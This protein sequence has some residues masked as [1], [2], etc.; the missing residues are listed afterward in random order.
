M[1][2]LC[3]CEACKSSSN[4]RAKEIRDAHC[5]RCN[6]FFY[7]RSNLRKHLRTVHA[8]DNKIPKYKVSHCLCEYCGY[9]ISSCLYKIHVNTVHKELNSHT[10]QICRVS[11]IKECDL[12]K[13]INRR[14][15]YKNTILTTTIIIQSENKKKPNIDNSKIEDNSKPE[16]NQINFS[17]W[18]DNSST[19]FATFTAK[20]DME[21][22][23]TLDVELDNFIYL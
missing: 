5:R 14:H 13:H 12:N 18:I 15:V 19:L 10:C 1:C 6:K 11:F 17:E 3:D 21:K 9:F 4:I 2:K 7:H 22:E 23:L 20:C 8:H 16:S